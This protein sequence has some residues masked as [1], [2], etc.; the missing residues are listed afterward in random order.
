VGVYRGGLDFYVKDGR[1]FCK[2]GEANDDV[3]ELRLISGSLFTLDGNA[4][5]QF[6]KDDRGAYSKIKVFMR[7]GDIKEK[8][9][10]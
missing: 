8:S 1:L 7:W 2:N 10:I 3:F 9:K 4:Q 5:V 6:E